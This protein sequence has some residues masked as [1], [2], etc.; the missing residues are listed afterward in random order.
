[1]AWTHEQIHNARIIMGVGQKLGASQRDIQIALM[2]ALTESGLRNVHYGDRDSLG[3]FQ[4]RAAWGSREQRLNV[5]DSAT[6]FFQ[7]GHAGQRGLF[8]FSDRDQMSMGAA[9]QAVQVSAFPDRYAEHTQAAAQLLNGHTGAP[10][11]DGILGDV[12][13]LIENATDAVGKGVEKVQ[14]QQRA[15]ATFATD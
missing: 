3:V 10:L 2:V 15:D 8:D 14:A 11:G 12:T 6:M 4:Q 7:G 5:A 9:A 1:M 13:H